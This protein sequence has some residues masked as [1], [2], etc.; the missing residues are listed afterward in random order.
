MAVDPLTH[1]NDTAPL[2]EAASGGGG[3]LGRDAF[4][5]L[6]VAQIRHQDP[7]K[8]MDD[9]QFVSQLAQYSSLEQAMQSNKL[10]EVVAVQQKGL[11]NTADV[12]LVGKTVTVRGSSLRLD[13][14]TLTAPVGFTMKGSAATVKVT[15]TDASGRAVRTIDAGARG[16][17]PTQV[18]WDGKD[19]SGLRQPAGTYTVRI[20]AKGPNGEAVE[21]EQQTSGVVEKVS[22]Q[23][24]H[25]FLELVG[26]QRASTSDL[27]WVAETKTQTK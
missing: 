19:D 7:L 8:P 12:G 18:A 17:G 4:L 9:T 2:T 3:A 11:A 24:G 16:V 13:D 23:N 25:A 26:G 15:I 27:L 6:L 20:D 21:V 5:K 1:R 14:S 22:Y 10:L